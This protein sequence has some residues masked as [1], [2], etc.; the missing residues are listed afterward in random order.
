MRY[1]F[2]VII[3][4]KGGSRGRGGVRP[5]EGKKGRKGEKLLKMSEIIFYHYKIELVMKSSLSTQIVMSKK[6]H[7]ILLSRTKG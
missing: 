2:K 7:Q 1:D 6:D 4:I 5:Q 3:K